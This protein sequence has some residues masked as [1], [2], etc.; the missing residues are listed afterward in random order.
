MPRTGPFED[1]RPVFAV[2]VAGHPAA[3]PYSWRQHGPDPLATVSDAGAW[4][5]ARYLDDALVRRAATHRVLIYARAEWS[6]VNLAARA[7]AALRGHLFSPESPAAF[8]FGAEA[9]WR[10]DLW[11]VARSNA[12]V[13]VGERE[14][15]TEH[16]PD[17]VTFAA[18]LG[19]PYRLVPAPC[20]LVREE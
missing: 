20:E 16:G 8:D 1:R 5:L 2:T 4:P 13:W 7:Y 10:R 17:L 3:L 18:L 14:G 15:P 12:V 19:V 6:G 9:R 11:M